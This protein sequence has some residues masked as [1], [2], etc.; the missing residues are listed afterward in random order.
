[1]KYGYSNFTLEILE[2]CDSSETI[3]REQYYLDTFK[4][5]YNILPVAGSS[6]GHK[7]S[8]ETKAKLRA[9]SL[10]AS[11]GT[12]NKISKAMSRNTNR[13]GVGVG[14]VEVIDLETNE[15]FIFSSMAKAGEM[16][17]VKKQSIAERFKKSECFIFRDRYLLPRAT[18]QEV[19]KI[20]CI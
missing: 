5:E 8:E 14:R 9:I 7:H 13:W 6:L 12:R 16:L 4:P 19:R 10:N 1:M 18:A 20:A 17:G 3:K 11:E 2:Y 15:S